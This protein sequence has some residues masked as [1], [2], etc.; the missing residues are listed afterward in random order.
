VS[1]RIHS[2]INGVD[3]EYFSPDHSYANPYGESGPV[4]VFTGRMDYWANVDAV[5]WFVR[6]SFP[7]VCERM[8]GARFFI[9]GAQPTKAVERLVNI[10]GVSV[11]GAVEDVRPYLAHS[12]VVVAPL[13][14]ARGIQNKVLE[15]Y[16]MARPLVATRAAVEGLDLP[17]ALRAW[18]SDD[19]R[20]T[21]AKVTD[22]A[23]NHRG[24]GGVARDWVLAHH[25]WKETLKPVVALLEGR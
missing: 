22:L 8:A 25:D 15:A 20:D 9:V 12:S 18:V 14:V 1:E 3:T 6:E 23:G 19:P 5:E 10:P 2:V 7:V 4:V 13:R 16:A 24:I 21:A 11:T 17:D